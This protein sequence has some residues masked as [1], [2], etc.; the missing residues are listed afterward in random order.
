MSD[1]VNGRDA[2]IAIAQLLNE[3][4]FVYSSNHNP[5]L[6]QTNIYDQPTTISQLDPLQ[7]P[8]S[9]V[10]QAISKNQLTSAILS[11]RSLLYAIPQFYKLASENSS[12]V[13]HVPAENV[14][15]SSF[16]DF[17]QVMAVRE[18]GLALL[19]SSTV[20]EAHDLSLIAHLVSLL[21]QTP[22][23]HFFDS[24]R[25][26]NELNSIQLLDNKTLLE[27]VPEDLIKQYRNSRPVPLPQTAYLRYNCKQEKSDDNMQLYNT[28]KDVMDQFACITARSYYPFE[29]TG[30]AEAEVVIVA[31][32]AGATVVEE[33]LKSTNKYPHKMG[34]I[35][36]R[37]YRPW[38]GKHFLKVL[39]DTVQRIA[40]LEPTN[41]STWNPLFLDIAST[42]QTVEK[43]HVDIFS[44][45]YG[46]KDQDFSQEMVH[47]VYNGLVS[48]S[49]NR[50]FT[51][52][53]LPMMYV[54]VVPVSLSKQIIFIGTPSLAISFAKNSKENSQAYTLDETPI[55]HVR[56]AANSSILS[57]FL[58]K[59]ADAVIIDVLPS[60]HSQNILD[61]V[62]SLKHGGCLIIASDLKSS[63]PSA[64]KK[65]AYDKQ[66]N[67]GYINDIQ[68][69]F[70]KATSFQE[71]LDKSIW[72]S[73]PD[74]WGH[75]IPATPNA[76]IAT[77]E[78][79]KENLPVETPYLKMLD[80]IFG[81]RLKIYNAY[82]AA[83]IWSPSSCNDSSPEFG[84]GRFINH[85]QERRRLLDIVIELIRNS[86]I[87]GNEL[88]ILTQWLL[89]VISP[90]PSSKIINEA[91]D[92][93]VCVLKTIPSIS[94]KIGYLYDTSNWLIGS[95]NWA[96]DLG[97][98][99]LH[100][101]MTSGEYINILIV[102]TTPYAN[103]VE[104]EQRKKD[105]GLYAMNFGTVYVASVAVYYSYTGV[106]Q[107][108]MEADSFKG[109][110]I[111]L[112]FLPQLTTEPNTLATLKETKISVDNGT[113]PLY[114]W[115]PDLEEMFTLDSSRIKK[116]LESFLSRENHLTQLASNQP[117]ISNILVSSLESDLGRR[118]A[119]LKRKAREDY[120][121]LL[122]GLGSSA[123]SP[124]TVLF[125]SDNGNGESIAKKIATRAKWRGLPVKLMAMDDYSDITEL[126]NETNLVIICSTAG[127]GE[128]PYNAREFWKSLNK[129][130]VGDINLSQVNIGIFGLGDSHYWPRQ[131]DAQ[132][133]NRPAKL[134][135]A[136]FEVLGASR[137][138]HTGLA[139][140]QDTDGY[141]TGLALWLPELWKSLG[142]KDTG[143]DEEPVYT[144][145]QMK[146][147][148][149]FLRGNIS[150]DMVDNTTGTV[151]EISQ[152][153]LK[154]HGAY[155]QDDR[156]LR[157]E[158][159]S[160]GL[161]KAYSFLIR[162]RTPGGVSTPKQWLALDR[163]ADRFGNKTLKIT[164][165]QA[166]QLHGVLKKNLRSSIRAIN[167]SLLSTLAACGDV[168]RNIMCTSVT[169]IPEVREQVQ[170]LVLELVDLLAPKTSAYHEIWLDNSMV[171]GH[172][173]Q[174]FEPIYGPSYLP[175]KFKIV[176][177]VPP[178]NDVDVYA[179]DLGYVAIVD[180]NSNQVIGYNVLVGG[181]MG[182]THG[183]KKTYPRS[184]SLIGYI[185]A[186]AVIEVTKAV[187]LIQRDHGDRVNRKHARF[188]YTVDNLGIDCIKKLIEEHSGVRLEEA[189][190]F[191]FDDNIDR[192]GWTKGSG[193]TW[194]FGMFI[195]N[196]RV[197]DTPDFLCKTGLR[198][199]AKFHKGEFRLTSNQHLVVC[200]ISETD[201]E[202]T[203]AHLTKY[204]LDNLS[205]TGIRKTSSACVA[206]PT[207]GLAMAESERYLPRLITLL[208]E[209][210]EESGIRDDSIV[211]RMTGCPN[212]CS[213]PYLAEL[214]FVGK[215]P[216]TYNMYLGGSPK[217]ERLNKLYLE[218]LKEK[219]ILNVMRPMIKR[220]ALERS[221]SEPFG[222][223]VIKA[224]YVKRTVTGKDFHDS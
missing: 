185:S 57:P 82:Q 18:S 17:T 111:V 10:I 222:D 5:T 160:L 63:L 15:Q 1:F 100:H 86:S 91:A 195:E 52:A 143:I 75:D 50:Q 165:R 102:D 218:N 197:K 16:A 36:V 148:S 46:V 116:D 103:Q 76:P 180:P 35:K 123:G 22:F 49:L 14:E 137:L 128:M 119:E 83:S 163:L 56:L 121:R 220:Y 149:N 151:S 64:I 12:I 181:G 158:R 152:K 41:D 105:I 113:W 42:L 170:S 173:V 131:E 61:A 141:Q 55:T 66:C 3:R 157:E 126:A 129:L 59:F 93:A 146:I 60:Q 134:L 184:A 167:K 33:T 201:L 198:E 166:Y 205:F 196:G 27:L 80:Q 153:L 144:D 34:I 89:S 28:V 107:A 211:I 45:Q 77:I 81:S 133:Y 217:G 37:L 210:M 125:G 47:A 191:S 54:D 44:G 206:L 20:Q 124:L 99:G 9:H 117:D 13:V 38:Y 106:L 69:T 214:A 101:V 118:H 193:G 58:I 120:T 96:Y 2:S 154:F 175:R 176:I 32:G 178:N 67:I 48:N 40:V 168:N 179:H 182:M 25:I 132:F 104:R 109:P 174:D 199:L 73:L 7:D 161:E 19:C 190:P 90:Q 208:E 189:K 23:L 203:K 194:N 138:I 188:K 79:S 204:K 187:V 200:N 114:R 224:G 108:M 147:D 24:K 43:N 65:A 159:K 155:V 150:Q 162:V 51:V 215:A 186:K 21:T 202:R 71:I 53:D 164:T 142:I 4:V 177:A 139:D 31:M 72:N 92:K 97:Q 29:Y 87:P 136:K 171:A 127:Q 221:D 219:D 39:P 223:W 98:S 95:D 169:E 122:S 78:K 11:T 112:A 213:R 8:L 156:D 115:N 94:D 209:I 88:R 110:S 212:G 30:D 74:L 145:D 6:I 216:E 70:E 68:V 192:Y 172:A 84:Y 207:C 135:D 62:T 130:I 183:N 140:D 85:M 26:S